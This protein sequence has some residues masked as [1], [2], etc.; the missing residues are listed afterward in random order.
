MDRLIATRRNR[1]D[2]DDYI[3]VYRAIHSKSVTPDDF[4]LISKIVKYKNKKCGTE[5]SSKL[6][7]AKFGIIDKEIMRLIYLGL[8][9]P[10]LIEDSFS[11]SWHLDEA[12]Y[13]LT[14]FC[15]SLVEGVE[16][17]EDLKAPEVLDRLMI[18]DD[19]ADNNL[20]YYLSLSI[21][22]KSEFRSYL[23]ERL[24]QLSNENLFPDLDRPFSPG[25]DWKNFELSIERHYFSKRAM[26][27][28]EE[29]FLFCISIVKE[30]TI[31]EFEQIVQ[32]CKSAVLIM[33]LGTRL[34]TKIEEMLKVSPVSALVSSKIGEAIADL[35]SYEMSIWTQESTAWRSY[36]YDKKESITPP[37]ELLKKKSK[38]EENSIKG[39]LRFMD[40]QFQTGNEE[41]VQSQLESFFNFT[42]KSMVNS[43]YSF[44]QMEYSIPSAIKQFVECLN[45]N[46]AQ[47]SDVPFKE[48][49]KSWYHDFEKLYFF[50]LVLS[51]NSLDSS[52]EKFIVSGLLSYMENQSANPE[53]V[54]YIPD[55]TSFK[56]AQISTAFVKRDVLKSQ[57]LRT[58]KFYTEL[59]IYENENNKE[60]YDQVFK[61][62]QIL[63]FYVSLLMS[64]DLTEFK[65]EVKDFIK[66]T[67]KPILDSQTSV[68]HLGPLKLLPDLF[69]EHEIKIDEQKI[70]NLRSGKDIVALEKVDSGTKARILISR[71]DFKSLDLLIKSEEDL[72][73][74]SSV[75]SGQK[76][77]LIFN[78]LL[79]YHNLDNNSVSEAIE[80]V[81]LFNLSRHCVGVSASQKYPL[82]I[83][84]ALFAND[85]ESAS[86]YAKDFCKEEPYNL[87]AWD[88]QVVVSLSSRNVV[89]AY[90]TVSEIPEVFKGTPR[91]RELTIA[92]KAMLSGLFSSDANEFAIKYQDEIK[93]N[94]TL[95]SHTISLLISK[96]EIKKAQELCTLFKNLNVGKDPIDE[97]IEAIE[98]FAISGYQEILEF[99]KFLIA[100]VL[101]NSES[102]VLLKL[103]EIYNGSSP[104]KKV[105]VA[106]FGR[107]AIGTK[108]ELENEKKSDFEKNTIP[109]V[110]EYVDSKGCNF[111]VFS[112]L[113]VP[114]SSIE[115]LKDIARDKRV[116]ILGGLQY[117]IE[118]NPDTQIE[119]AQF[120]NS[121]VF[122]DDQGKETISGSKVAISPRELRNGV[123][124][125]SDVHILSGTP[126]GTIAVLTC[127]ELYVSELNTLLKRNDIDFIL[128]PSYNNHEHIKEICVSR[129][130]DFLSPVL[131]VN[132]K[133]ESIFSMACYKG[134]IRNKFSKDAQEYIEKDFIVEF[135]PTIESSKKNKFAK[136]VVT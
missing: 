25:I 6:A 41:I 103:K 67:I 43:Q 65:D 35:C 69:A 70:F 135:D 27:P 21:N 74:G 61:Y 100:P 19:L 12:N 68:I 59:I 115:K 36:S 130:Y 131:V 81:R 121:F 114:L 136:E 42:F 3:H 40:S 127:S 86:L 122:I 4:I 62:Q 50:S 22:N 83:K 120:V 101:R 2:R 106:C 58:L 92:A 85:F 16:F 17:E 46:K 96:G 75:A 76:S 10:D 95:L 24:A 13:T 109:L 102:I 126:L 125:G 104:K 118:D 38:I 39:I 84:T 1:L 134:D 29:E 20:S 119:D 54:P 56:L 51:D 72:E 98:K 124:R 9:V 123:A 128:S 18:L 15:L 129:S 78:K 14:K 90:R 53:E 48:F 117:R 44:N 87:T 30:F 132:G 45:N 57:I 108:D 91:F 73:S 26:S 5:K 55:G 99:N 113:S 112:E 8:L 23:I 133:N 93:Y 97:L 77:T 64:N 49:L 52:I 71:Q 105:K 47:L 107:S 88:T 63:G 89:E 28:D 94:F 7:L 110:K 60:K 32:N 111:V 34:P 66:N 79:C 33:S 11:I 82:A 116:W 31:P 37:L 80:L